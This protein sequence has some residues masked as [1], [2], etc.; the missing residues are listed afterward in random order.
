MD[1]IKTFSTSLQAEGKSANT[2]KNYL[3]AVRQ[4]LKAHKNSLPAITQESID[5]FLSGF[6]S[7]NQTQNLKKNAIAKFLAFLFDRGHIK[8][9]FK[10]KIKGISMS[11]PEYLSIIEQDRFFEALQG[12][13]KHIRDY[14]LFTTMLYTG[15]RI[16][17]V[18]N[19]RLKDIQEDCLIIRDSKTGPGKVYMRKK[20]K[21]LLDKY[22]NSLKSPI[23]RNDFIFQS[24][25]KKRLTERMVQLL[26]KK[27]LY[28]AGI[29]KDL[30]PHS[31]R[32]T[33]AARLRQSGS[34]IEIIQRTLRHKHIQSTMRYSHIKDED[35]KQAVERSV[36]MPKEK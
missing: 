34:D 35:L 8:Q 10:I 2:I 11:E 27:Y 5:T 21:P 26:I 33:F 9:P 19:L 6:N 29:Q 3:V 28:R 4:F 16:S 31:L 20:L 32:H 30:T 1:Y 13:P 7:R 36:D 14:I 24:N 23:G 17:E 25:Q 15:L 18:L 12:N 22:L